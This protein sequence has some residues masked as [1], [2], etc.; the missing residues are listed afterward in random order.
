MSGLPPLSF[1]RDA[2]KGTP[3]DALPFGPLTHVRDLIYYDGPLL[4]EYKTEQGDPVIFN[5]CDCDELVNRWLVLR[6]TPELLE[7]YVKG[8]VHQRTL[9]LSPADGVV[10]FTDNDTDINP[11][12]IIRCTPNNIPR[13]YLPDEGEEGFYDP[14]FAGI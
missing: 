12:N 14:S 11:H 10:Y 8:E 13:D 2:L 6:V 7:G 4:S 3:L 9:L 1:R 5:W